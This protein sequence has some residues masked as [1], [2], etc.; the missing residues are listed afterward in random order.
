[1]ANGCHPR[2]WQIIHQGKFQ[3]QLNALDIE[4]VPTPVKNPQAN[5]ICKR[6]HRTCGDQIRTLLCKNPPETVENEL[7]LTNAVL[8]ATQQALQIT[9]N[10]TVG[11]T[12]GAMVFGS[13]M[14]LPVPTITDFNMIQTVIDKKN[15]PANLRR[16]FHDYHAGDNKLILTYDPSKLEDR[17]SGPYRIV[18]LHTGR[19]ERINI[20]R[21]CPY[22]QQEAG[23]SIHDHTAHKC[24]CPS[25]PTLYHKHKTI[26]VNT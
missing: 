9:L 6:M 15:W 26:R 24:A 16:R 8:A 13:D 20:C 14:L 11:T 19:I 12:P 17:A 5:A 22:R 4:P 25:I 21:I 3:I 23:W 7:D 10:R 18:S 2:Q 1:M